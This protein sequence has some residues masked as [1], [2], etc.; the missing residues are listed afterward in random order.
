MTEHEFVEFCRKVVKECE[1]D[2]EGCTIHDKGAFDQIRE[3]HFDNIVKTLETVEECAEPDPDTIRHKFTKD[4]KTVIWQYGKVQVLEGST[5]IF[6]MI[7]VFP[8]S[9][10]S[11]WKIYQTWKDD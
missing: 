5:I 1:K 8:E 6:S 7:D 4:G 3:F 9:D 11:A 10:E 2:I